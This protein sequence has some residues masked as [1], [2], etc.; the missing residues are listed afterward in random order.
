MWPHFPVRWGLKEE[1]HIKKEDVRLRFFVFVFN[2]LL[3]K[4]RSTPRE[5]SLEEKEAWP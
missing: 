5:Q 4:V 2:F 3:I 1:K